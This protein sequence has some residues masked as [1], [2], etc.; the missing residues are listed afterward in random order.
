MNAPLAARDDILDCIRSG[1][2]GTIVEADVY[3]GSVVQIDV[4]KLHGQA[5][6]LRGG[7]TGF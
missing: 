3:F 5:P 7:M 2:V 6:Y 1:I 4:V